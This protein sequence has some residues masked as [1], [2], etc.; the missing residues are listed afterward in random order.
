MLVRICR[1]SIEWL[2]PFIVLI[3]VIFS[4]GCARVNTAPVYSKEEIED[5]IVRQVGRAV[6]WMRVGELYKAQAELEIAA[7]LNNYDPRVLDG[8]GAVEYRFGRYDRAKLFFQQAIRENPKYDRPYAHL[9]MVAW[10][11]GDRNASIDLLN[12]AIEINPLNRR[13]YNNLF[14]I[15]KE[16]GTVDLQLIDKFLATSV[17]QN[18]FT[19]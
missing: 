8:L 12:K 19:Q 6:Y 1:C 7:E 3:M 14:V 2:V 9:A 10:V 16:G 11:N 4:S 13:N 18:S 15:L 5:I 17:S